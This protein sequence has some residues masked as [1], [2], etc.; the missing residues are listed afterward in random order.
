MRKGGV[1]R[2]LLRLPAPY[3]RDGA[4]L[5]RFHELFAR[6]HGHL[7]RALCEALVATTPAQRAEMQKRRI[8]YLDG[9]A[10]ARSAPEHVQSWSHQI[11]TA[12]S[13]VD[14]CAQLVPAICPHP[15]A[16]KLAIHAAWQQLLEAEGEGG[17]ADM[18][19][20]VEEK[21]CSWVSRHRHH[22]LPSRALR[23]KLELRGQLDDTE[24]LLMVPREPLIGQIVQA[25]REGEEDE[26]LEKVDIFQSSLT[27]F[28]ADEGYSAGTLSG[29]LVARG[30]FEP[31]PGESKRHKASRSSRLQGIRV[32]VYRVVLTRGAAGAEEPKG[33]EAA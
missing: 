1:I 13:A 5:G 25:T 10:I 4:P 8:P 6:H 27:K 21:I 19:S 26:G 28:L 16:W 2:R 14:V 23:Q 11:A 30:L 20:Q 9:L 24:R 31:S 32:R 33:E 22:L 12:L 3:A 29:E 18:L 15:T 17:E 7:G